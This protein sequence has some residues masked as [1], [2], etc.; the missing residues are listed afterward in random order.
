MHISNFQMILELREFLRD[1]HDTCF[2]TNFDVRNNSGSENS[3]ND[4]TD[5]KSIN[6]QSGFTIRRGRYHDNSL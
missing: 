6:T 4:Y 3:I 2:L 5:L 1:C